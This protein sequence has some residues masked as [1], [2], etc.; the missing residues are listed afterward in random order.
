MGELLYGGLMLG[1]TNLPDPADSSS[2][3]ILKVSPPCI[4][5]G[6]MDDDIAHLRVYRVTLVVNTVFFDK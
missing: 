1:L 2:L 6:V 5:A 3:D 4:F